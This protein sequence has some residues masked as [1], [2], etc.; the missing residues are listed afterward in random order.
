MVETIPRFWGLVLSRAVG[1]EQN[2]RR[3]G[4]G[5]DLV[6]FGSGLTHKTKSKSKKNQL[7][8]LGH[9]FWQRTLS[10]RARTTKEG[11]RTS[12]ESFSLHPCLLWSMV[13]RTGCFV[14]SHPK[15][16]AQNGGVF[17][18]AVV[19]YLFVA[20]AGAQEFRATLTGRVA[21]PQDLGIADA[22][23]QTRNVGTNEV[24]SAKT[25]S[26][27]NFTIPFLKPGTYAVSVQHP[28]FTQYIQQVITLQVAQ[29]A[30]LNIRLHLGATTESVTVTT[31]APLLESSTADRGGVVDRQR[32]T[33]LPLNA[34]NPF[35]LGAMMSGVT[36]RGSAIWQRPF[37]NGAIAEWSINGSRQR[38]NEFLLDGAPNNGQAGGNNIA[39]VPIVDAVQE[40]K[41]QTNTYDAQYG[42]TAG[43]IMNVVMKSGGNNLHGSAWEFMR[44][45][46]LDANTFQNKSIGAPRTTHYLDQYGGQIEGPVVI[47][48][49]YNGHNETFFLFSIENYRE[50]TPNPLR[51]SVP[52]PEFLDGDFSKL[53]DSTGHP[54]LLYNPFTTNSSSQGNR[55][56]FQ[57]DASGNPLPPDVNWRQAAGIPCNKIPQQMINPVAR[58]ILS[59]FPKPNGTTPDSGYSQ[60]NLIFPNYFARDR[61]YNYIARVDQNFGDRHKA[62]VR[63]AQNSRTEERNYNGIFE[64]PAQDGQQPFQRL[65]WSAVVDWVG[66]FSPTFIG[67]VRLSFNRFIE[68][69]WGRGDLGFDLTTLGFPASTVNQLPGGQ[70]FGRYEFEGYTSIGRYRDVNITNNYGVN[71]NVTKIWKGHSIHTGVDIRRVYYILQSTGNIWRF[72][73]NRYY[74]RARWD[75][76]VDDLSGDGIAS[77]LMGLPNEGGSNYP[78]FPFFRQWYYAPFVQGDWK[79]T[80]RLTLNLGLRWDF[81]LAPDEKYNRLDYSFDL[82]V[83]SQE[84]ANL[85]GG[86]YRGGLT[87]AGVGGNPTKSSTTNYRNLQ[88]RIGAAYQLTRR[89]VLRGGWGRYYSNPSNDWDRTTGFSTS[90]PLVSST[91]GGRTPIANVLS[92]PFPNGVKTPLTNVGDNFSWFDPNFKIP[93]TDQFS[94]GIQLAVSH[95]SMVDVGYVGSRGHN[96]QTNRD[97]NLPSLT[98]RELCNP[99]E[100]GLEPGYGP[101]YCD[102]KLPNP[103]YQ[104]PAFLGTSF[105]SSSTLSRFQLNRPFPQ[106]NGNLQQQGLNEG[107]TW[108]NSL[109]VNYNMRWGRNLN[110]LANYTFAKAVERWGF[111]DQYRNLYQQG[112]YFNDR[113]HAFK[114]T[115]V[116]QL[117]FGKGRWIAGN[118]NR[119]LDG[120]IG[121]W[122]AT[123]FLMAQSGEPADLPD[124]VRILR[125]PKLT[126]D[127]HSYKVQGWRPY[128]LQMDEKTGVITPTANSPT[129]CGADQST[130]NF[131]MLPKYAPRETPLRSGR[132]RMYNT[133]TMDA[134]LNKTFALS[135]RFRLQLRGEAFDVLNHFAMPLARFN[136]DPNSPDFGSLYPGRVST[137][138]S[139]MPRQLQLAAKLIF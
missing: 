98:F 58:K 117:P 13:M 14:G 83:Q 138:N 37:D 124:N 59:Y 116:F 18:L 121:G 96:L 45:T 109:Q 77:F 108:Y 125:D 72:K 26:H 19:F 82:N 80:S 66:T 127:W 60:N 64:G 110:L 20:V 48:K 41:M 17:R 86:P 11:M 101:G 107:A 69:G 113:P 42:H 3:S 118:A 28:G 15:S 8:R 22:T 54:I 50:G 33:E 73:G 85:P 57:C 112:L 119:L 21:D 24:S 4:H 139:G 27:G 67:N 126:P 78:L 137:Q 129:Y 2:G 75:K 95:S 43:G 84:L 34:R 6:L 105:Y 68:Q 32:V 7:R 44:R 130:Y 100:R 5:L 76:K 91:D 40:F 81:N 92:N 51:L 122:E 53:T 35:M 123:T 31:E 71:P 74:T 136:T 23:V 132:I 10:V 88:P 120:L 89:M 25:D 104:Q 12:E 93:S 135:E 70:F 38:Q 87:F 55:T 30:T 47:P 65:N 46:W 90:T 39:Y 97:Y 16:E 106:F 114:L 103:F 102:E 52:A 62:F 94:F 1:E 63:Y 99:L 29:T 128:V 79:V 56:R 134:S 115:T 61:F 133:F 131:L 111:T 49:L 9:S 36:F